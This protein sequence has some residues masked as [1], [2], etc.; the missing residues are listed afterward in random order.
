MTKFQNLRNGLLS[1]RTCRWP[2]VSKAT[3]PNNKG[4]LCHFLEARRNGI[5]LIFPLAGWGVT[6][7]FLLL[8]VRP[9]AR[10]D[11]RSP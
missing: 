6:T 8:V 4:K 5:E 9:G 7:S 1:L 2:P 10:S 3:L 11:A